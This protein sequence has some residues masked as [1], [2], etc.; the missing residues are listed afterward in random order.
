MTESST[1]TPDWFGSATGNSVFTSGDGSF[2]T[3]GFGGAVQEPYTNTKEAIKLRHN[4][5]I[6]QKLH[7]LLFLHFVLPLMF[8]IREI[9]LLTSPL[10][11]FFF[12]T[13]DL[14][15]KIPNFCNP[16]P[17]LSPPYYC[18]SLSN[19]IIIYLNTKF[20]N[21]YWDISIFATSCI[22]NLFRGISK[23]NDVKFGDILRNLM[24]EKWL[25]QKDLAAALQMSP[26]TLGNY[27]R[28]EREAD[29]ETIKRFATFF[30]VS[31]DYLLNYPTK[32]T[33]ST[34]ENELMRIFRNLTPEQQELYIEQGR[35][36]RI[37]NNKQTKS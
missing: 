31:I 18:Q 29:Y 4:S 20:V 22:Y 9:S 34:Q 6:I 5:L 13:S 28:N 23:M 16:L 11:E 24:D 37:L 3:S 19:R 36:F 7:T 1:A 25:S 2:C 30:D 32:N 10:A 15:K 35:A 12:N 8:F 26:S 14:L 21:S 17:T 27:I 33:N